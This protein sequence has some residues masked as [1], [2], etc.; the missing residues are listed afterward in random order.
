LG[1]GCH[2]YPSAKIWA[3]WNLICEDRVTIAPGAVVYNPS[4]LFMGSHAIISQDAYICG[5]SHDY[6]DPSFPMVSAPI[7]LGRRSWICARAI[8]SMGVTVGDG[9]VLGL[10]SVATRDLVPWRVYGGV[11]AREV[12]TRPELRGD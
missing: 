5:A 4:T 11:P 10:G 2:I 3:P 12:G 6:R 8:V 1:A 7:R 9:A